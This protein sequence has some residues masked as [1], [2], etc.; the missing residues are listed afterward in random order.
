MLGKECRLCSIFGLKV[1]VNDFQLWSSGNFKAVAIPWEVE[2]FKKM[3]RD[4]FHMCK[5]NKF[6]VKGEKIWLNCLIAQF[7]DLECT[8]WGLAWLFSYSYIIHQHTKS[9]YEIIT[10][11][12][13]TFFIILPLVFVS[14]FICFKS[15]FFFEDEVCG[16]CLLFSEKI[17]LDFLCFHLTTFTIIPFTILI[18]HI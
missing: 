6:I 3:T 13:F 7:Q 11:T 10:K 12:S 4:Q 8:W 16:R 9:Q 15:L 1:S 18:P 14:A 2:W 17:H 5:L